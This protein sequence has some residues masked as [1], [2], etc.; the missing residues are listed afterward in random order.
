MRARRRT[1]HGPRILKSTAQGKLGIRKGFQGPTAF[2]SGQFE[3]VLNKNP[4]HS[5][6]ITRQAVPIFPSMPMKFQV[7]PKRPGFLVEMVR[8]DGSRAAV[9]TYGT[10]AAALSR[11]RQLTQR[12]ADA[13]TI[14]PKPAEKGRGH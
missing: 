6:L 2:G 1:R 8:A 4:S 10:E 14:R 11:M 9:G 7:I 13:E 3:P 12:I 5:A